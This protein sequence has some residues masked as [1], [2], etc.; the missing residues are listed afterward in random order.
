MLAQ[1]VALVFSWLRAKASPCLVLS[2]GFS[3]RQRTRPP[4]VGMA[5]DVPPTC[6]HGV[7]EATPGAGGRS[8]RA[9]LDHGA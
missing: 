9:C 6:R 3:L 4:W 2:N 7:G 5:V 8:A 1:R